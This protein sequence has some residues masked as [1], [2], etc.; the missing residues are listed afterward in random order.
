M[1]DFLWAVYT[2]AVPVIL[3]G[4]IAIGITVAVL[5]FLSYFVDWDD[6]DFDD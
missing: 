5:V 3:G 4:I 1:G 6:L 2:H